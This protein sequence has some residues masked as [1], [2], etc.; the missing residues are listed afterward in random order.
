VTYLFDIDGTLVKYHTNEWLPGARELLQEV[1][2]AGHRI[3]LITARNP[4]DDG[5]EWSPANAHKL[6]RELP[7]EVTLLTAVPSRRVVVD[8][9]EGCGVVHHPQNT[10]WQGM[11]DLKKRRQWT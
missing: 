11:A 6:A 8:D 2:D 7:F 1:H 5:T 10:P 3:I 9:H 4:A